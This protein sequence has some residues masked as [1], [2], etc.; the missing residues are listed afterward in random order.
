MNNV[1]TIL[2]ALLMLAFSLFSVAQEAPTV[3]AKALLVTT[4]D[5]TQ[6]KFAL[7][8]KPQLTIEKPY[9]VVNVNG[10]R[11]N[12]ELEQMVSLKYINVPVVLGDAY[13]DG[14]VNATDVTTMA[15]YLMGKRAAGF[16]FSNAD[17]NNDETVNIADIVATGKHLIKS[18]PNSQGVSQ[19]RSQTA[20]QRTP[21]NDSGQ[22][23]HALYNYR[24]DGDFNAWLNKDIEHI[25]YSNVDI[26]GVEQ[27]DIVVQEVWTSDSVYRIPLEAIDSIGFRKPAPVMREGLFYLRDYHASHTMG[28]D[29]LTL[30]FD[31]SIHQ[32]S[33]PS[34]GQTILCVTQT[35]P[36]EEGFAG[37][38]I[39][40][41]K[42]GDEITMN[43]EQ[44]A[45]GD[46]F[47]QLVLVGEAS[48][49]VENNS[50][51]RTRNW[52]TDTWVNIE[53]YD[54]FPINLDEQ[55][56][57]LFDGLIEIVSPYPKLTCSYY[58]YVNELDYVVYAKADLYH[59][60]L[61]YKLNFTTD[62]LKSL[63]DYGEFFS[64]L[65]SEEGIDEWLNKKFNESLDKYLKEEKDEQ[66]IKAEKNILKKVWETKKVDIPIIGNGILNL[67]LMV[68]PLFKT[69]GSLEMH[70]ELKTDAWQ[71]LDFKVKGITLLPNSAHVS[72][73]HASHRQ[74]PIK[75]A[76]LD[77]TAKGTAT[78]GLSLLLNANLIHRNVLYAGF[79]GELGMDITG[80]L[81]VTLLDT[82]QPEMNWY[83]RLKDTQLKVSYYAKTRPEIG[84]TPLDFFHLSLDF[85][86]WEIFSK[87]YTY[88]IM[89][90]FSEPTLPKFGNS[91]WLNK[92]PLGFYSNPSK[93]VFI[94]CKI[95]MRITDSEGNPVKEYLENNR[96]LD[97]RDWMNTPL[98]INISDLD[99]GASYKCYPTIS[100][101]NKKPF[102]AGPVHNFS[103]P[104]SMVASP[105]EL[106]LKVGSTGIVE[107]FGGWDTF[108]VVITGDEDVVSFVND[109]ERTARKIKVLAEKVGT[110][111]LQIEDRRTG[112]KL[113]VPITVIDEETIQ[114]QLSS[115]SL[116]L[117]AGKEGSVEITSGSG[118]YTAESSDTDVATVEVSDGIIQVTAIKA[119]EATITVTD[120]E[121]GQT[122][123]IKVTVTAT[124]QEG[125]LAL[126]S[127]NL[128][129]V[130]VDEGRTI[131]VTSGSGD[132]AVESSKEAVATVSVRGKYVTINGKYQGRATITVTD[133][134]SG[135]E[136]SV[137]V[138]VK[139]PDNSTV[140]S[141]VNNGDMEGT[142]V[143]SFFARTGTCEKDYSPADIIDGVGVD[144]SR[145][146][147]VD[148]TDKVSEMWDNQFWIR[149][150]QPISAGT[151]YRLSFDYRADT[152]ANVRTETH[153][154]PTDW[155]D[156]EYVYLDFATGWQTYTRDTYVDSE[157]SLD[158]KPFQSIAFDLSGYEYANNYYFDNVKFEVYLDG[159]CPKPTFI[160]DENVISIS[161]PFNAKI[162]Y[163]LDGSTPTTSSS[164]YN[165]S[166]ILNQSCTVKAIAVVDGYEVSPVATYSYVNDENTIPLEL[167]L[168][169]L[170]LIAGKQG[171]VEIT[172]G[173]GN[174]M[175]ESSDTEVATVEVSDGIIQV[176]AIKAGEATITITD[177]E[178]DQT[179][180]IQVTVKGG[181]LAL[182]SNNLITVNVDEGRTI[183]ITSGSGDYAVESSREAVATV[184][185]RGKYVTINGKYQGRATITVIDRE[186]GQEVSVKLKVKKPDN[187]TVVSLIN[188]GD[189]EGTDVGNFFERTGTWENPIIPATITDGVGVDG[190]RGIEVIAGD[191]VSE[192][193]DNQFW[194]RFDYPISDGTR[195]R[196]SYDYRADKDVSARTENHGEPGDYIYWNS[197]D[198]SSDWNTFSR[199]SYILSSESSDSKPFRSL[200]FT[201]NEYEYANNYYFD[202]F[203]F[204]VYLDGQC[205]KPAFMIDENVISLSSPFNA[206]IY[207][208]LDG[209]TPT[210]SSSV[211]NSS[212]IL[213]QSCTVKAIAVVDGYEVSPVA[214]YS[215]TE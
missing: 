44:A 55:S 61:T 94:P 166:I 162:Y 206:K 182:S 132:Y 68:A 22:R 200:A 98:N 10:T 172:S 49:E 76:K 116:D 78:L 7:K 71:S 196:F 34:V 175:A 101:F 208:T 133:R 158:D 95:G 42:N 25:I 38:V 83:D 164:V 81:N 138:K 56:F 2:S 31:L 100:F 14:V 24:N 50:R 57:E 170:D 64:A 145:G 111:T 119:G 155:I 149:F 171:T 125:D 79:G 214:T 11:I 85:L 209:S 131:V 109:E 108:A 59:K 167:S 48:S 102:N 88:Y 177:T 12:F 185:V 122:A 141:L 65:T 192:I 35:T 67:S 43:C 202:N 41:Q 106:T 159:Q 114:I 96:Y 207:Y 124:T 99:K 103:V 89:P 130:N 53:D 21:S 104:L 157:E 187:S 204:E 181:D 15:N 144:G 152:D 121:S 47:K 74:D 36:Y 173:S 63:K 129:T 91:T 194:V 33:L 153:A 37:K 142:D 154:E 26:Q 203:I 51:S 215:Y 113:I 128:I 3:Y 213:N 179:A 46:I 5:G 29:D 134:E 77:F 32:D 148:A 135:Q 86:E 127:R 183:V 147:E 92:N 186:S 90:H 40:I 189:L 69:E 27:G 191:M 211:Y 163:T 146:L 143:G 205:P 73:F 52:W 80:S 72:D 23:Q 54:T 210:T 123:T 118:N 58:V 66:K 16:N 45:V 1:K 151:N 39:D 201:L 193:W 120:T 62:Q 18:S 28:V 107:Y 110:T 169:S 6:T 93:D 115:H 112:E 13:E 150:D 84:V 87:D 17:A 60:D 82:E 168:A 30:H 139:K 180:T 70:S 197:F 137:K 188:N 176:T 174:Y 195:Y 165:S 198:F 117:I 156:W 75:D 9:L 8:E 199:E 212:I 160:V 184:S 20:V 190:S 4:A 161:S 126:S 105:S 140:V 136:V 97:E 19:S 178:S